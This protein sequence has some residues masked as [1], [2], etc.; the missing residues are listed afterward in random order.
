MSD[1]LAKLK[2]GRSVIKTFPL[3]EVT[4]GLRLLT[5]GDYQAAG[6][7]ANALLDEHETELK[8]SNADLFES[9]KAT[10]LIMRFVVDPATRQP[11]FASAEVVRDTLSREE[12]NAIADAYF[13]FERE[14]SPSERTMSEAAFNALLEDVKKK[15]DPQALNGL[16]GG[17]LRRLLLSLAAQPAS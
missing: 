17:L 4:L 14:H 8:A 9:E 2:A 3:G 11:V 15:R 6:W 5:E 13:D 1:I 16:S 7:A 12:R 10:H